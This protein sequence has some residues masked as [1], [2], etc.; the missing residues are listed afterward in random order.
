[1]PSSDDYRVGHA[2]DPDCEVC[3][4]LKPPTTSAKLSELLPVECFFCSG[5]LPCREHKPEQFADLD[6][7][8]FIMEDETPEEFLERL[9]K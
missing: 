1:M 3:R 2:Y 8:D 7:Q 5:S 6:L 9:S 4:Q